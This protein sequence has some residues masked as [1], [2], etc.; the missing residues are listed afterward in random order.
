MILKISVGAIARLPSPWMRA[1]L[2]ACLRAKELVQKQKH[3]HRKCALGD[4]PLTKSSRL[5][6]L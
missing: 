2:H 6:F 5:R 3:S 4:L 1:W